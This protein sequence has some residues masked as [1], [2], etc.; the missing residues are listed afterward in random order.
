MVGFLGVSSLHSIHCHLASPIHGTFAWKIGLCRKPKLHYLPWQL[1]ERHFP[2]WQWNMFHPR[3]AMISHAGRYSRTARMADLSG[4]HS[5]LPKQNDV[6]PQTNRRSLLHSVGLIG[7]TTVVSKVLGLMREIVVAAVFGVGPV[8]TAFNY[9]YILPGFLITILGGINGPFHVTMTT[10]LS[11][12]GKEESQSLVEK[13][14]VIVGLVGAAMG[15]ILFLFAG[16]VIDMTAPGLSAQ[17][18]CEGMLTR[19]IAVFQ[20]KIMSPCALLAGP[21][22]IGFG[23]LSAIG[24]HGVPSISPALS[25]IFILGAVVLHF[26]RCWIGATSPQD[27]M[28]GGIAIATGVTLGALAQWFLQAR[29]NYNAGF[30]L[31]EIQLTNLFKDVR[32]VSAIMVPAI[33]RSGMLQIATFTDL[34][35]ASFIPG[36][37]AGLGYANLLAMTP[38]GIMSNAILL[39]MLSIFSHLSKHL[40]WLELK[41]RIIQGLLLSMIATLPLAAIMIPLSKPI[42]EVV[43]QH[44]AFDASATTLVSSLL[45]WYL[46]GFTFY[47]ARDLLVQVFYAL[48]DGEL[49]FQISVAAIIAN[50]F[51]DWIMVKVFGLGADGLVMATSLVNMVSTIVLL[52]ILSERLGG[53]PLRQWMRS[54]FFM[55]LICIISGTVTAITYRWIGIFLF[56]RSTWMGKLFSLALASSNG[57]ILFYLL[58]QSIGRT[59]LNSLIELLKCHSYQTC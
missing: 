51:C 37:A 26:V 4:S 6:L 16:P 56:L 55:G 23:S 45:I 54:S 9:S 17:Q 32:E 27:L 12:H 40:Q 39:P 24:A 53:L 41:E 10:V 46:V 57:F 21:I 44:C 25:S 22:G 34:Y 29:A 15:A 30:G 50:A 48:D 47:L 2:C 38:L 49:P 33:A 36:A 58:I 3:W 1:H 14:S 20:L 59:E 28:A 5:S 18:S 43:F 19:K 42:V 31:P 13:V 7:L 35:F 11:K 8:V 52:I